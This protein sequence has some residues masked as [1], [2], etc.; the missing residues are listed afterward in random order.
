MRTPVIAG[1]WKMYNTVDESLKLVR[2]LKQL[3]LGV[4]GV[5]IVVAPVF[6]ALDAVS[7]ESTA[8]TYFF[9]PR[10]CF[11]RRRAPIPAK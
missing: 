11:G 2:E 3:V 8:P 7:A 4:G 9:L 1:N 10:T 6:T 5:E